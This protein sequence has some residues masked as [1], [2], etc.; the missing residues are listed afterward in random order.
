MK[1][2]ELLELRDNL[3]KSKKYEYVPCVYEVGTEESSE[4]NFDYKEYTYDEI[5]INDETDN[6]IKNFENI[7]EKATI[8][9]VDILGCDN[10]ILDVN[11]YPLVT[12]EIKSSYELGILGDKSIE[13]LI[14]NKKILNDYVYVNVIGVLFESHIEGEK[15]V[16]INK[17]GIVNFDKFI[18]SMKEL[19]YNFHRV[20]ETN[21][22][23]I[24]DVLN[25]LFD[26][27]PLGVEC[28]VN[29]NNKKT[30]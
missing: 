4:Y 12:K 25:S 6:M 11:L 23:K 1:Y 15:Y 30:I 24:N 13:E 19:G 26:V 18:Q 17:V 3:I 8:D 7:I 2:D 20:S 16:Y 21:E 10:F 27:D 29:F 14:N 28:D 22:I 5:L 9:S